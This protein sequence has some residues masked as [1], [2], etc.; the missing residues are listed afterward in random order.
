MLIM[1]MSKIKEDRK[2]VIHN[3]IAYQTAPEQQP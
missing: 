2:Q 3:A 1:M